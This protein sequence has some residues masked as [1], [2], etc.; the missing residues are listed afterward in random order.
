LWSVGKPTSARV[1]FERALE[2]TRQLHG[3]VDRNVATA[4]EKLA[5]VYQEV[6]EVER[7][8]RLHH[9]A[10]VMSSALDRGLVRPLEDEG[11]EQGQP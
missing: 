9:D 7:A 10:L 8:D 2:A 4:M 3:T 6:G 1:W 5:A 11:P